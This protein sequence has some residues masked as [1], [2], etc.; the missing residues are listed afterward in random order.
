MEKTLIIFKPEAVARGVDQQALGAFEDAGLYV[1]TITAPIYLDPQ[2]VDR[3]YDF[4]DGWFQK[5]GEGTLRDAQAI[6]LDIQNHLGTTDPI[7]IG[8]QIKGWLR[9]YMTSGPVRIGV[10]EGEDAIARVRQI[11]GSTIPAKA[12]PDTIRGHYSQDTSEQALLEKRSVRNIIHA[13]G[14]REEAAAEIALWTPELYGPG[15]TDYTH[16]EP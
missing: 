16:A 7:E 15:G 11:I 3:H 2:K 9:D 10:V 5:V 13:S 14:N 8:H 6:G 1:S 12:A 4:D